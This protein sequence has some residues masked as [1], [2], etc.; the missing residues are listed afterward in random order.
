MGLQLRWDADNII[1]Q[2]HM[3]A[4]QMNYSGN[5]GF[6]QWGCKKDLIRVKYEVEK[7]LRNSPSFDNVENPFIEE[8]ERQKLWDILKDEKIN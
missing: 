3:C 1:R 5:D 6:V 8:M 2:L 7:L 4:S